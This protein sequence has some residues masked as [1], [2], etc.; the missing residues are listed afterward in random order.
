MT[1][2]HTDKPIFSTYLFWDRKKDAIDID[3]EKTFVIERVLTRGK[4]TDEIKLFHYYGVETIKDTALKLNYLDKKTLNY[5]SVIFNVDVKDFKCY[6]K[7][8]SKDPFGMF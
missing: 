8:Q 4:E 3:E 6:K 7:T 5:L 2:Q 1:K